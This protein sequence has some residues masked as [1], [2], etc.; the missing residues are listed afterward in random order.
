MTRRKPIPG[1]TWIPQPAAAPTLSQTSGHANNGAS[2]GTGEEL[3]GPPSHPTSGHGSIPPPLTAT[4]TTHLINTSLLI[5]GRGKPQHNMSVILQDG[6]ITSIQPTA[7]VPPPFKNLPTTTVPVLMPGLWD[8]HIHLLG[9]KTFNFFEIATQ[10][11]A[12]AGARIARNVHDILMSGFTSVRELAGYGLEVSKAI[13]EGTLVGPNIYSSG[14]AISQTA[15]H[16]DVFDLPWGFVTSLFGVR[17]TQANALAPGTGP[18]IIA[19][20]VDECRRAVR[21]LVRRGATC[22]KVFAS[23]GVLSIA[24]DPLRQQFSLDELK[25][26]V[27]EAQRAGRVVGA[28]C[29]GKDG[30][31]AAL[32]AGVH[33]IEHGTYMDEEC[34]ELIKKQGAVYVPTRTIVKVGVDHPE[35]M[36]PESYR[37]M[38]ETARHHR[39]AYRL[40]VKSGVKIAL[41]TDL[42]IS[43]PA[44]HPL[45]HG[46]S[47]GELAYAVSDG[48][49]EPLEAIEAATA[50]GPEVLGALGMA[51]KSGR[52]EV[53]YD[54]DLIALG[55]NPLKDMDLFKKPENITH[56]WKGGRL[57]KSPSDA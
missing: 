27:E 4:G 43:A 55:A 41:G 29:H 40:A 32:R 44:T 8:C 19:D 51:P 52:I 13:E 45:A 14:A 37:K 25:V 21:L 17:D 22:I 23:G 5:P 7:S 46:Q 15:G 38:L 20:G 57:F 50:M 24:D 56:V 26:I 10:S 53:G 18:M 12:L 35:L 11:T 28:H 31:M 42:G 16:G 6:T 30:I 2:S 9:S 3:P 47:G 39:A 36:S 54:A 49:M 1:T 48:G 33:S 34:V